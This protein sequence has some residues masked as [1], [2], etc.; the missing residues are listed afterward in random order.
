VVVGVLVLALQLGL[1]AVA[2]AV[3]AQMTILMFQAA[4]V[5]EMVVIHL[6]AQEFF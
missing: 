3:A 5:V 4:A 6:A 2:V 1:L